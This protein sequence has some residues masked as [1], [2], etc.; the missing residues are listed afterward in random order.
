MEVNMSQTKQQSKGAT[1]ILISATFFASYGIWSRLMGEAFGEYSQAW[2]RG[3][4]LLIV[5]ITIGFAKHLFKP[6]KR[7]DLIWF[8][9]IAL[10]GGLNQAPYYFGFQHLEVGTAT[11]LFYTALVFGGYLIGKFAFREVINPTKI[12]ALALATLGLFLIFQFSLTPDQIIPALATITAGFMGAISAVLPKKLSGSYHEFQIMAGYFIVMLLGN[13]L[14]TLIF[15]QSLPDVAT[16]P[17][18]WTAQLAYAASLLIANFTVIE[19]FKYLDA[20]VGSLFG[21]AEIILS[22]IFAYYFF[23]ETLSSTTLVGGAIIIV[24]AALPNLLPSCGISSTKS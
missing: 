12:F 21:L 14:L 9:L 17:I 2:S 23:G 20:T 24:A 8:I 22:V 18:A 19:G 11:L 1:F 6:I 5:V 13:G 16:H 7:A 4:I 15:N 10:A 3:L